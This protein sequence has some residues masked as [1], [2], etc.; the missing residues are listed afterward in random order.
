MKDGF[1]LAAIPKAAVGADA[2]A[3]LSVAAGRRAAAYHRSFPAYDET[4]LAELNAL[5]EI[6]GLAAVH[7]KDES[8]R[9]GLNAFKVLG[10]S[11]SIGRWLAKQLGIDEDELT[12]DKLTSP[13]TMKQLGNLTF[14]TATDGNHGRGVA[15][16]ARELGQKSVVYMPKGSAKE[17]LNNIK[18]QGADTFIT[19]MNYDETVRLANRMGAENG[20]IVVQDTAWEGYEEIPRLIMQ[21]YLTM[22][23]EAVTQLGEADPTHVFLQAGV[24][25]MAAAIAAFLADYYGGQKPVITVVEPNGA[26]CIYQSARDGRRQAVTG[27]LDTIMA[28]LAC[29]EPSTI[30]WEV[31]RECCD[32]AVSCPD[33]VAAEGM[34][35]LGNAAGDDP[36]VI[37]G[38]SG[39]VTT[40]LVVAVMTRPDLKWLKDELKLD[41]NARVLC[42]ST[43]GDTDREHY[44]HIVWDGAYPG[45]EI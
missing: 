21:G 38:E 19:E 26:D 6:L 15:W 42:F 16:T 22:A 7:V 40:G 30:A 35:V 45:V 17:R 13:Q 12:Y 33:W 10:G 43:E 2:R 39:A 28:G 29:G 31:I 44:R 41:E 32:F 1:Y 3:F 20:W 11:Y 36:K 37:S 4:P 9:F 24:G 25:S 5:A 14:V 34:R 27:G 18:A 23:M 8:R